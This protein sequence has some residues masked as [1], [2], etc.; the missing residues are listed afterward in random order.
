MLPFEHATF[1]LCL[2]CL[3]GSYLLLNPLWI[4][5]G[6]RGRVCEPCVASLTTSLDTT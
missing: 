3:L 2:Q 5:L 1:L 4:S 6:V